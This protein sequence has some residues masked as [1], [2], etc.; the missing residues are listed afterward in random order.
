MR[1][2]RI[3]GVNETMLASHGVITE[4]EILTLPNKEI[5]LEI[6]SGKGAF[7]TSLALAHPL[8]HFIAIEKNKYVCY[9]LLEKK[10]AHNIDNLTIILGD[11]SHLKTY[12][13]DVLVDKIYLNFSDPWPKKK[14]H[15]RRLTS[16][17][18]IQIYL[19][20]LKDE[21]YLQCRTDH[22]DFFIY[23]IELLTS[24]FEIVDI[25]WNLPPSDYMT[26]YEEKK[27]KEGPIYQIIGR[28]KTCYLNIMKI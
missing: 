11:A 25:N 28:K 9:R 26:E 4:I 12:L 19:A 7:I 18:F 13:G 8:K 14:H 3:K 17:S 24:S 21:G 23:S 22:H 16:T 27:R 5:E 15:K 20:I 6:G 2:K 10:E 1:Q